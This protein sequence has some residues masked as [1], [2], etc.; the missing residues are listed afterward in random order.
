MLWKE[1]KLCFWL[2]HSLLTCGYNILYFRGL[3][4]PNNLFIFVQNHNLIA[5]IVNNS[6]HSSFKTILSR[7]LINSFEIAS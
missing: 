2:S 3:T 4:F 5:T 1:S 6:G 7:V